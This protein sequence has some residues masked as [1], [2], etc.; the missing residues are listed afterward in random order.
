MTAI[1]RGR[2][3]TGVG[4]ALPH[5]SATKHVAGTA[6]YVDDMPE[7]SGTLHVALVLSP[8]AHG[9]LRGVDASVA[10]AQPG[11]VALLRACDI[12]GINDG[13]P[14]GPNEPIFA[15]DV[16]EFAGQPV[17]A[18]VAETQDAARYAAKAVELDIAPLE[19]ILSIDEALA[20]NSLLCPP[21]TVARGTVTAVLATAPHR[22]SH[23]MRVGGQEH[24]YLEG[25]IALAVPG[26]DSDMVIYSSTQN[27]GE[28]QHISARLL[29]LELNRVTCIVRRLGGGF[30][31]KESN[32][33]AVAGIAA[34]AAWRTRRPVKLRLPRQTDMTVTGKRHGYLLDYTVGF[35]DEGRVLALDARL[36]SNGG[37]TLDHSGAVMGRA[38]CHIDNAYWIPHLR[39]VGLC[40]K[41]NTVSNTA[42]RG[43]G[44][45]QASMV[46]EDALDRIACALGKPSEQVRES[47]FY[48]GEGR[49]ITPYG[50]K[51]ADNLIA[52]CVAQAKS[53][54]EWHRRRAEIESFNA[55]SPVIKRGL[56]L[57]PLKFG[58]SFN[59]AHLNQAGA[60]VNV[61]SDGSIR[62]NHGG[63]EMGQGLFTKVAQVVAE[64]FQVDLDRIGLSATSTGEVPNTSPTA[65]STGSDLNGWAA[66]DAASTLKRRMTEF[67]E[68]KFG[69]PS[70]Q[71]EFRDN[72]V[73]IG[74]RASNQTLEFGELAKMCWLGR[75]SL[76]ATGFYRTPDVHWNK[77][78]MTGSPFFYFSYGASVA[79]VAVDTLTGEM[80]VLRA[81]LVQDCGRP[82]NPAID[83]GQIEGAFVQG[84]GWLTNEELWWDEE[85]RLRT[86][87]PSTYKI[88]GSR[89]VPPVFNVRILEDAPARAA[90]IFR[91]KGVGEPPLLLAIAVWSAV[92]DAVGSLA[93]HRFPVD[94]DAPA[95]PERI[96][97]AVADLKTRMS[98]E[99]RC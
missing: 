75:V 59:A 57:F 98:V 18:I 82:L 32:S 73:H 94:L 4:A 52:R 10:L 39:V 13:G 81:D 50:Q 51:L 5:D 22:I 86:V 23:R 43:Y 88:P 15:E 37:N 44:S 45:P 95:T 29:G 79:E 90:T 92:R 96:L 21:M 80:R 33:S 24:F 91:S 11:V 60:L 35:D 63:T 46:M 25:Q 19:P 27:P 31:G 20:R 58:I 56:A 34:L 61:Y 2:F 30:G 17:A 89:D 62:L 7:P 12:P 68:E 6:C 74:T 85:G 26:E 67:A 48:G 97:M 87:G 64:V 41:T 14:I 49:D 76:S 93:G 8:V 77:E 55:S 71:I 28:V 38:V 40:C 54:G 16:V 78:T 66:Y 70:E 72:H 83:L 65:A 42:F 53:D 9:T 99:G 1:T 3:Q 69:V 84:M 47:N 36:A